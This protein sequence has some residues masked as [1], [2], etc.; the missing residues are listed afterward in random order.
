MIE[1]SMKPKAD[2]GSFKR[3][4]HIHIPGKTEK[5]KIHKLLLSNVKRI[6]TTDSADIKRTIREHY[7]Q[8]F[9]DK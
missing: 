5:K 9:I 1:K 3:Y 8:L 4:T 2:S 6:I 7:E